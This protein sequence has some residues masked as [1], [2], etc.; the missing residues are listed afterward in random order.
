MANGKNTLYRAGRATRIHVARH[1][2]LSRCLGHCVSLR[3]KAPMVSVT[4]GVHLATGD[5]L[6]VYFR[7]RY[8][9]EL[10]QKAVVAFSACFRARRVDNDG[11]RDCHAE[12]HH[13]LRYTHIHRLGKAPLSCGRA[14]ASPLPGGCGCACLACGVHA[15]EKHRQGLSRSCRMEAT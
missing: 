6:Y 2:S 3:C 12:E 7:L 14:D 10:R 15:D 13:R 5:L 8:V 9:P 4:V 11:D 1:D